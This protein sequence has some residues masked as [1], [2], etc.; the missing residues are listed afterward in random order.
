MVTVQ[1]RMGHLGEAGG[2]HSVTAPD[3]HLKLNMI[4]F[5]WVGKRD[6]LVQPAFHIVSHRSSSSGLSDSN[7]SLNIVGE[8]RSTESVLEVCGPVQHV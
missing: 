2:H 8:W 1:G 5:Y 7:G 4:A 6:L 3:K